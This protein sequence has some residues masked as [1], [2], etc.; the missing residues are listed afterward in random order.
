MDDYWP[1]YER[2]FST[3]SS[4]QKKGYFVLWGR[5][6]C[7]AGM[8]GH[9]AYSFGTNPSHW[10]IQHYA[11]PRYA[12]RRPNVFFYKGK[13]HG[14]TFWA[15]NVMLARLAGSGPGMIGSISMRRRSSQEATTLSKG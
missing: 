14:L 5:C 2:I 1:L 3:V 13:H 8:F 10:V 6:L 12:R 15:C 4:L 11:G 9:L 7:L